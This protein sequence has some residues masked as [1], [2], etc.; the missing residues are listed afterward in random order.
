MFE[1]WQNFPA[2]G[3]EFSGSEAVDIDLMQ[4]LQIDGPPSRFEP[5]L[6]EVYES[7]IIIGDEVYR[8][9]QEPRFVIGFEEEYE[10]ERLVV[11]VDVELE[12]QERQ[13]FSG[14]RGDIYPHDAWERPTLRIDRFDDLQDLIELYT[15]GRKDVELQLPSAPEIIIDPL[16]VYNDEADMMHRTASEMLSE[17]H[18]ELIWVDTDIIHKWAHLKD[19]ISDA[20]DSPT[21]SNL[22]RLSGS[23]KDYGT[24]IDDENRRRIIE[25]SVTRFEMRPVLRNTLAP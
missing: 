7:A 20:H 18:S 21:E 14:I 11:Q 13:S 25:N 1:K 22:E 10:P 16:I 4:S 17:G 9:C 5:R 12:P 24:R 15:N 23:M 6:K 3:G 2:E 19:A 8:R